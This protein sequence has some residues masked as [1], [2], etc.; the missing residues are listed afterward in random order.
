MNVWLFHFFTKKNEG[1]KEA[2]R[3]EE[4]EGRKEGSLL[5]LNIACASQAYSNGQCL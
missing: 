1:K 5:A 4:R 3:Y 2:E